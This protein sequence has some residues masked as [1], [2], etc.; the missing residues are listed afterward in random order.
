MTMI[1]PR[2]PWVRRRTPGSHTSQ[3]CVGA[4]SSSDWSDS[5]K[6][7]FCEVWLPGVRGSGFL[8]L[9]LV[10]LLPATTFSAEKDKAEDKPEP[11][12]VRVETRHEMQLGKD[13]FAYLATAGT[14]TLKKDNETK[15]TARIFFVA[16]TREGIDNLAGRPILFAFNG[17]PGSSSVW[18]H[19][20]AF[21]P[22]RVL[23]KP[24]GQP[25]PPPGKVVPNE[26]TLLGLTDLVFIDPVST[27]YSR[28][29]KGEDAKQFHGVQQDIDSVGEFIRLYC[30]RYGRWQ[31]PK[32]LCG[33]SYG[34]TRAA[35]LAYHLQDK[36]GMYLNGIVLVSSVLNFQTLSFTEGNDLPY[37][38]FLPSYS[39]TA[40]YHK[41]LPAEL[42]KQRLPEVLAQVEKFALGAYN[43]ALVQG[44]RLSEADHAAVRRQL[45]HF[46]G[47][48]EDYVERSRLRI[49]ASHFMKELLRGS[50]RTVGR[51]D[52]R[53]MG[54]DLD[55]VGARPDY[56]PSYAA[57]QG[58]FTAA[59]NTY[60]RKDLRYESDLP[61]EVLTGK[62]RPW[63]Y[64]SAKN[65][66]LNVAPDLRTAMTRNP[67]LKVFVASG[68]YDLATPYLGTDY[69]LDHLGLARSLKKNVTTAYYLAGH[70]MYIEKE[71]HRKLHED[72]ANFLKGALSP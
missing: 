7:H 68:Y 6:A 36:L 12:D 25:L 59:I 57:V 62:V 45:A 21:G 55:A 11:P 15:P 40:W 63:D 70:M 53:L 38:L 47:L 54:V 58:A 39:A 33:E 20:G 34:T 29:V 65:R 66:Y 4:R 9:L 30:A 8:L 49:E 44:D 22:R 41:K 16:Y 71:S 64:G 31:S 69:T 19:M 1:S 48:S 43:Q 2:F 13:K 23:L 50:E 28:P 32:F 67:A 3:K 51:Y 18:L 52:S 10:L 72:V 35:G 26:N 42:Q 61:Y 60:L 37:P 27:G 46:T 17:G 24:D 5:R 14:L 56:D